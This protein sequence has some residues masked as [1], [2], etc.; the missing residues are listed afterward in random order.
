MGCLNTT[1]VCLI[2]DFGSP[3]EA[4]ADPFGP[5][6]DSSGASGTKSTVGSVLEDEGGAVAANNAG[7]FDTTPMPSPTKSGGGDG[8]TPSLPAPGGAPPST[9]YPLNLSAAQTCRCL[10]SQGGCALMRPVQP[11]MPASIVVFAK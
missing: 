10:T 6:A 8:G 9:R 2:S 7:T 4:M 5:A 3:L 11:P 1:P